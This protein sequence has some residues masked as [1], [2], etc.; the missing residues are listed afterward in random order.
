MK[1]VG[2][3][4]VFALRKFALFGLAELANSLSAIGTEYWYTTPTPY[5]TGIAANCDKFHLL[6]AGDQCGT[7]AA[8]YGIS[9]AQFYQWNPA[10]GT[11]CQY[12]ALGDYVCVDIIGVIPTTVITTTTTATTTVPSVPSNGIATPTPYQSGM[13]TNCD[14]FHWVIDGDQCG[15]I[16]TQYGITLDQFY[17]WNPAVGTSCQFLD[18]GDYVCVKTETCSTASVLLS[19]PQTESTY[20]AP[21]FL[22]DGATSLTIVSYT[23]GSPYVESAAACEK[24]CRDTPSCTN[25][26]FMQ[27][28]YCNL[29]QGES[30]FQESI[31][32]GYYLWFELSCFYSPNACGSP[33][34][35]NDGA[36][37]QLI[38][39]YSAGSPYV[40]SAA[41]CGAQCLSVS[42]CTNVY[43]IAGVSCNLHSG[44]STFGQSTAAGYYS[45]YEAS[46]FSSGIA[47]GSY[48]FSDDNTSTL[49]VSYTSGS[50]IS[51][52]A[53]C[54]AQCL[55]TSG[56]TNVYFTQGSYC[57]LHS[58]SLFRASTSSGYYSWYQA[59]CFAC[60]VYD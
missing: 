46:C 45:W 42:S 19:I 49:L 6:V 59:G 33:G 40:Q 57:N 50:Y 35:S 16:A 12:L 29:H 3:I 23:A 28:S 47:C 21:G 26:Y 53:A 25:I 1:P 4:G 39:S 8:E 7:L 11:S 22:H 56:C 17:S 36:T 27:G 18:I 38:T 43:F 2:C 41:A 52:P 5:R 44:N 32:S 60:G 30:T 24:Q 55:S 9:L 58:P 34:F 48:G 54:G 15:L 51:S 31:A 13:A 37:S 10:V 20:G 14:T